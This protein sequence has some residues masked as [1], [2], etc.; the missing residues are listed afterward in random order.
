MPPKKKF[1]KEA[2]V[3]AAFQVANEKGFSGI[4][5][6][7]VAS[8]LNSSV[9]PIYVNFDTID[10]L[11][12][13]VVQKVFSISEELLAQQK[14][15]S[16]FEKIGLASLAFA[17][18]YPVLFQELSI[19]PNR[20]LASYE[21]IENAMI[22]ALA[23]DEA[24]EGWTLEERKRLFLKMRVFQMGL[25]AMVA[26]GHVPSWLDDRAV[27]KLFMEVGDD[28]LLVQQIKR[29]GQKS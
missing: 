5:A 20:Y 8:R 4:T 2:I 11:V 16:V 17:R 3:E 14:G 19:K 28:L 1:D 6:R 25:S 22:E 10:E 21:T 12:E 23:E 26:N 15:G 7:S 24:M 18:E 9:A 29:K 27:E 13:V